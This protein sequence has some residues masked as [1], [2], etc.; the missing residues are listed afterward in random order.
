MNLGVFPAGSKG[1]PDQERGAREHL[2]SYFAA[3]CD[4]HFLT[5]H[6]YFSLLLIIIINRYYH[7]LHF[8]VRLLCR[9]QAVLLSSCSDMTRV[10]SQTKSG[11]R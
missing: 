7:C 1:R 8:Q 6:S 9:H 11:W 3:P 5:M 10:P 4:A 2:N